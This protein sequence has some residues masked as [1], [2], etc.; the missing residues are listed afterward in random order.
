MK[1]QWY[2]SKDGT[3]H[4]VVIVTFSAGFYVHLDRIGSTSRRNVTM[5]RDNFA[6]HYERLTEKEARA[7]I[8]RANDPSG[9]HREPRDNY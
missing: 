9:D 1:A 3:G 8:E 5:L 7:R 4:S 2:G 6:R